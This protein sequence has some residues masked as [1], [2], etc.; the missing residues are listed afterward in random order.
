MT[1]RAAT[2]PADPET[3]HPGLS[4]LLLVL[5]VGAG[6]CLGLFLGAV[7]IWLGYGVDIRE[8]PQLLVAPKR[9][10]QAWA[11]LM[12]V[13]GLQL[14]GFG[15]A[16]LLP[17]LRG[18]S[19]RE[20]F[21]PRRPVPT[22]WLLAAAL[23]VVV[24]VPVM[25]VLIAWNA[26]LELPAFLYDFYRDARLKEDAAQQLTSFL[27]RFTSPQRLLVALLV[28]AVVPAVM[29]EL[30]FRG[31]LL[32]QLARW[33]KSVH[34]GVWLSAIVFSY[35]HQQFFG[36]FPRMVLGAVLGY[37][38]VWSGNLWVSIAAHF[39]QNA[40]QLVLLYMQQRGNIQFDADA[41]E[42]LPWPLALGS[43][44]LTAALLYWLHRQRVL[45]P[46]APQEAHTLTSQGVLIR[47]PDVP[48]VA[49]HTLTSHG[50]E[51]PGADKPRA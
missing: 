9:Y 29:E 32:R 41:N 25:S 49:G 43:A 14:L 22:L 24:S 42:A 51:A 17:V 11:V 31:V 23:L 7:V 46:A 2:T 34:W 37:L 28:I 18:L 44:L 35:V 15:A 47:Q 5:L 1:P 16:Y 48:P 30:V 19:P 45:A 27:T 50:I 10:P 12:W 26:H 3:L 6:M 39:V 4:L 13:Q 33:T 38:F 36:F 40:F 20:Y 8:L 21:T